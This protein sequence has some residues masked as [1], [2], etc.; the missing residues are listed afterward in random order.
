MKKFTLIPA[1]FLFLIGCAA[2]AQLPESSQTITINMS[3]TEQ[4]P[5]DLI[6]FNITI[7]AEADTP[8]EA[9][10]LHKQR[11]AVLASLLQD[12]EVNE[13]DINYQPIRINKRNVNNSRDRYSVTNQQVSVSF[14]DFDLYEKIQL[15]LINNGFDMFNGRFSSTKM[16]EGKEK[17]L[18]AAIEAARERAE[19]IAEATGVSISKVKTIN[20]SDRVFMPYQESADISMMRSAPA[21]SMMDFA[22]TVS[23]TTSIS[24]V[25]EISD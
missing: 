2:Q 12:L 5:A 18:S 10:D 1:L 23:V 22:Q 15:T 16:E 17:A 14:S 6:I 8:Q 3:A 19:F 9:F 13:E 25:Y 20:Y 4:V 7:N 21:P 11:E 24:I